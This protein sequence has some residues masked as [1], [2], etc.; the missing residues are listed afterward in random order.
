[1]EREFLEKCLE[2]GLSLEEIGRRVGRAPSTVSH[3][4]QKYGL[5]AS[6]SDRHAPN[7]RVDPT[8]LR[9]LIEGGASIHGAAAELGV[10]YSTVRY[11]IG[12]LGL[13]TEGMR[14]RRQ[15]AANGG[16]A[17]IELDCPHHGRT[18]FHLRPDGGRRCSLCRSEAV[19]RWRRTVKVRLVE[20][21]GGACQVCGYDRYL[22]A[23]Q[24][25]HLHPASK[26]FSLSR[27]GVTRSFAEAARE[28]DGCV[29]LCANCHAEIEGGVAELPLGKVTT[30]KTVGD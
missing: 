24:F 17:P 7:G 11:W 29:L 22:G 9:G 1:V 18:A 15:T 3:H 27:A 5:E 19:T 13:E 10:A 14:R 21:A 20:R 8:H 6:G 16:A 2:E 28:A 25:H 26:R 23:L 12:R 30:A 4:L